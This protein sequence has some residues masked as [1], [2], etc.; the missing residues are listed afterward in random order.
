MQ[1]ACQEKPFYVFHLVASLKAPSVDPE[2]QAGR[3]TGS[4][5]LKLKFGG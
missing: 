3:R 2:K 4:T 1:Q 5:T